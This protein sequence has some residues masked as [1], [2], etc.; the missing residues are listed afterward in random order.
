MRA[1]LLF[2]VAS[3]PTS[4]LADDAGTKKTL[5]GAKAALEGELQKLAPMRSPESWTLQVT[6]PFPDGVAWVVY[7]YG[8]RATPQL[9][10]GVRIGAIF[11]EARPTAGGYAL[12]RVVEKVSDVGVQGVQ[13]AGTKVGAAAPTAKETLA[14]REWVAGGHRD[15][16]PSAVKNTYC[17][18]KSINDIIAEHLPA[19]A[20]NFLTSL[21]CKLN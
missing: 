1:A 17:E 15:A 4:A 5:D 6:P 3:L 18:W 14:A 13:P 16:M 21:A 7:G 10:D 12:K 9:S 20:K 2:L 11:A 8:Q 19:S